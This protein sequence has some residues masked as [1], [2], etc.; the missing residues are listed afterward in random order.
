MPIGGEDSTSEYRLMEE[1]MQGDLDMT[2]RED[3]QGSGRRMKRMKMSILSTYMSLVMRVAMAQRIP[4]RSMGK[5]R[6]TKRTRRMWRGRGS[7][8]R[9]GRRVMMMSM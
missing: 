5:R 4:I 2:V 7:T 3:E 8:W 1:D 9:A 6:S